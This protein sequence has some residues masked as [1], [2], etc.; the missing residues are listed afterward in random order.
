MTNV[1]RP[2]SIS[3]KRHKTNSDRT[4]PTE[5]RQRIVELVERDSRVTV[6]SLASLF[7]VSAVTVRAD[8]SALARAGALVRAHGG[9]VRAPDGVQD[10][11]LQI[12]E[13]LHHA[14]KVRIAQY[15]AEQIVQ[16]QTIILDSGT[17][18]AEIARQIKA[19]R[20]GPLTVIT[21]AL[22]IANELAEASLVSLIMVGG[23]LRPMSN[24]FVGPQAERMLE[25]LHA[26]HFLLGVDGLDPQYGL[27]TPGILEAQLNARMIAISDR[28][29]VVTDSSK[30]G[31]R[32]LSV[33]GPI[34]C[35]DCV[36]T[37]SGLPADA[38]RAIEHAGVS[39]TVV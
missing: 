26:D 7:G 17:T 13:G 31:R 15:V 22:N 38:K 34:S 8:L 28:T 35:A 5:R 14:E 33:I 32:S 37:D 24:S 12:K 27:S 20:I 19:R 21:N 23:I 16:K 39:V 25:D 2:V 3:V 1:Q 18:T 29:T 11:P 30:L 4:L 9:A 36:I 6:D 10:Y